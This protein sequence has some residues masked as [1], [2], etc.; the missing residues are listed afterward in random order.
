MKDK[1]AWVAGASRGIGFAVAEEL[2]REGAR[3]GLG[4]RDEPGLKQALAR[5]AQSTGRQGFA[6]ALDMSR[7]ESIRAWAAACRQS[8]GPAEILFIN[9]G[10]PPAGLFDDLDDRQWRAAA[11][12][13]LHGAVALTREV[14]PDMKSRRW[15]RILCLSSVSVRQ[16]IERLMLSNAL[17]A[18]VQGF[19]RSLANELGGSGVTVNCLAPGYTRTERLIELAAGQARAQGVSPA[20]IEQGWIASIP[21]GRLAEPREIAAAAAFLASERAAYIT[22]QLITVDGGWARSFS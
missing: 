4:A 11:D 6:G 14:L 9:S 19:A 7:P 2:A 3:I 1:T 15:G 17:R 16:P 18:A 5:I 22:G 12:L 20:E 10:G 21:L 8:L 13:L